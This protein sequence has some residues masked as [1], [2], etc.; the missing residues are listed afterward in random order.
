M[1]NTHYLS[2]FLNTHGYNGDLSTRRLLSQDINAARISLKKDKDSFFINAILTFGT[3]INSLNKCN[4]SWAFIQSYY[5]FFYLTKALLADK[6]YA[7]VYSNKKPFEI[8]LHN[9]ELFRKISGNSHEVAFKV[10]KK[11]YSSDSMLSNNIDD[12]DPIEWFKTN[13]ELINYRLNPLSDPVPPIELYS[14]KSDLRKWLF[15]YL[16]DSDSYSFSKHHAYIAFNL[17]LIYR[18][19]NKYEDEKNCNHLLTVEIINHLKQNIKDNNG[20]INMIISKLERIKH[21]V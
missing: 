15:T 10:F 6:E 1:A 14:F 3:C 7:I 13:R 8:K 21:K 5:C 20:P 17:N 9:D 18:E 16:N 2:N 12:K 11:V 4:Y 19:L